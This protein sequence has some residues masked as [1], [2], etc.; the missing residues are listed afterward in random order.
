VLGAYWLVS[1]YGQRALRAVVSLV[2]L[3]AIIT[4][5]LVGSELPAGGSAQVARGH[6]RKR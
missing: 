2:V 4:A 6:I 5:L 3:V 1:G